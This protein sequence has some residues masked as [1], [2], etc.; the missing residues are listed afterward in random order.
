LYVWWGLSK[1]FIIAFKKQSMANTP[2]KSK[3]QNLILDVI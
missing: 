2:N 1:Q 3:L